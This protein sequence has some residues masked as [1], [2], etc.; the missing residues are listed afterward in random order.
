MI[1]LV[2]TIREKKKKNVIF[3]F[4]RVTTKD[5]LLNSDPL[6]EKLLALFYS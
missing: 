1:Y 3:R 5:S 4:V 2:P 6:D